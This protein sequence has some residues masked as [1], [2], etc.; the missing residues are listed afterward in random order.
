ME[1]ITIDVEKFRYALCCAYTAG[2]GSI[3]EQNYQMRI[4]C[5]NLMPAKSFQE[6][7]KD[8][9]EKYLNENYSMWDDLA[10]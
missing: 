3:H 5:N 10:K 4:A 7:M 2:Q 1:E 8:G 9:G 6:W